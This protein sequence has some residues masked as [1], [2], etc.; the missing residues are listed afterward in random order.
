MH[1]MRLRY[2][3]SVFFSIWWYTAEARGLIS[4]VE[5][6]SNTSTVTLR[7]VGGDEKGSLESE[8]VKCGYESHGTRTPK[9]TALGM[10]RSNSKRQTRPLVR[11]GAAHE[12]PRNCLT[13]IKIW[14]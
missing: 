12:Q 14:S 9:I 3:P 5:A 6:G 4:R 10:A 2:C 8:T 7:I 1:I 11:E 13:I